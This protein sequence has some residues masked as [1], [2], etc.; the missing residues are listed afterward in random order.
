ML[1]PRLKRSNSLQLK[2]FNVPRFRHGVSS[3]LEFHFA[4]PLK[5][6]MLKAH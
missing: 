4:S 2:M 3:A 5:G 1:G 6:G